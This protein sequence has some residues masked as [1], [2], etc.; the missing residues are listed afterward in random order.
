MDG[1]EFFQR[2][3]SHPDLEWLGAREGRTSEEDEVLVGNRATGAK[4][5]VS[6]RAVLGHTWEELFAVLSGARQPRIMTH[7]TRIVG[8]FSQVENWNRSK[9]AEL[10]DRHAGRYAVPEVGP[11]PDRAPREPSREPARSVA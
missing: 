1:R 3:A 8:Y 4:F 6:V 9:L 5:A 10:R 7:I 2:V 11:R